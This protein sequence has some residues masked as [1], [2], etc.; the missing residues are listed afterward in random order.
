MDHIKVRAG[1]ILEYVTLGGGG[2]GNPLDRDA[3]VVALEVRRGL[4][5]V[6]GARSSGVVVKDAGTVD[7]AATTSLRAR[8]AAEGG[9]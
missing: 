3:E 2:W 9:R 7:K 4:V 8:M 6:E 1:D 5:S